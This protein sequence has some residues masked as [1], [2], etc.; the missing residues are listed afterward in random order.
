MSTGRTTAV[1]GTPIPSAD[2]AA[3]LT[4]PARVAL[5]REAGAAGVTPAT[6]LQAAVLSIVAGVTLIGW[7]APVESGRATSFRPA[8][9]EERHVREVA[10]LLAELER[11]AVA[12]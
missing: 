2:G 8:T 5:R 10:R 9:A 4:V 3:D 6:Q 11:Q 1:G 7:P 12:R